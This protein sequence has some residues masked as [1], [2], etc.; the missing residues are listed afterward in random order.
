MTAR[1]AAAAHSDTAHTTRTIAEQRQQHAV[2]A[3]LRRFLLQSLER[4]CFPLWVAMEK[5]RAARRVQNG[6]FLV[7]A[8]R[9]PIDLHSSRIDCWPRWGQQTGGTART[10]RENQHR[11]RTPGQP[12]IRNG[13]M[14]DSK[15]GAVLFYQC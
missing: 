7:V 15:E 5:R 2:S 11:E 3:N 9:R 10:T 6:N 4:L 8:R 12:A 13:A 1:N 14:I